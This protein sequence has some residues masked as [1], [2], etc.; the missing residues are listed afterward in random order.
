LV[1]S[2]PGAW[3][4]AYGNLTVVGAGRRLRLV[5]SAPI[6]ACSPA[7]QVAG[8]APDV[9]TRASLPFHILNDACRDQHP[10]ILL[11]EE[12][13]TASP[14][15]LERSYH[16]VARCASTDWRLTDGWI[17]SVV[18][19]S[20]PCPLALGLGWRLPQ[21]D[22][23]QGLTLD[24]RKAVAGALFDADERSAF[25]GLLLY[26]HSAK[27]ELTLATLSPN[28]AE[29]PPPLPEDRQA[30]PFFG[31]SL[32]CV[33][34][35]GPTPDAKLRPPVLAGAS[36]CLRAHRQ[37]Q[38]K[39]WDAAKPS[40]MP[41]LQ[42]LKSWIEIA[43]RTPQIL[44]SGPELKELL[45][46]LAA[47]ALDNLAQKAREER[48]LTERYAEL[49]EGLDDPAVSPAERERRHAE[50]DHLRKRLGG[51][52]VSSAEALAAQGTELGAVLVHLQRLLETAA[53]P[54]KGPR[55]AP[56]PD[57]KPIFTRLRELDTGKARTP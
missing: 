55:K 24:D 4:D 47:P 22:E 6:A 14:S 3:F 10:S 25:G 17:P 46:L 16:E 19:A 36:E 30:K 48:A 7:F 20:D 18:A 49:A 33:R 31:V 8:S 44:R 56:L 54:A 2:Q 5:L 37:A 52:I 26:A 1:A 9:S 41:E 23:L 42:K 57:Y 29:V 43:Q 32:R 35:A 28:A 45:G 40:P 51:Q 12:S 11:A 13:E 50:F 27:G 21:T 53:V 38:A 15:E 34:E 39:L